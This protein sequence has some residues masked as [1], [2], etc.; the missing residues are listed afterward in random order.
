MA[1]YR[2]ELEETPVFQTASQAQVRQADNA[3]G[4]A[5]K[6]PTSMYSTNSMYAYPMDLQD[7]KL[8]RSAVI[9][10]INEQSDSK[11]KGEAASN[12]AAV[13]AKRGQMNSVVATSGYGS[14]P[15]D[16]I[17]SIGNS[18]IGKA[19]GGA[20][21]GAIKSVIGGA[22]KFLA[23]TTGN[24]PEE[25]ATTRNEGVQDASKTM[26]QVAKAMSK[27]MV[28][29]KAAIMLYMPPNIKFEYGANYTESNV[30]ALGVFMDKGLSGQGVEDFGKSLDAGKSTKMAVALGK[31]V[32]STFMKSEVLEA[33]QQKAGVAINPRAEIMFVDMKK[34]EFS[35]SWVFAPKNAAEYIYVKTIIQLF[36]EHMHPEFMGTTAVDKMV[37]KTPSDFNIEFVFANQ[38]N[39]HIPKISVCILEGMQVQYN[40]GDSWVTHDSGQPVEIS[41][42]LSFK[43][44]ETLTRERVREANDA[45]NSVAGGF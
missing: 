32:L 20:I 8:R 19:V 37:Y 18:D 15:L 23:S 27:Q 9:F 6:N 24:S 41:L 28:R 13:E 31:N 39:P 29:L 30:G 4:W 3:L 26:D 45:N 34:R 21:S 38:V 44:L 33:A 22:D 43:E 11:F 35:F 25:V 36:K 12:A 14:A 17:K 1:T 2:D 10:Y 5:E 42:A 7:A 16:A 40:N